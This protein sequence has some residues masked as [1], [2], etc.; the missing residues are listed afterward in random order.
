MPDLFR[1]AR[2]DVGAF[3]E[4]VGHPLAAFQLR[5]LADEAAQTRRAGAHAA[6]TQGDT[7]S[8]RL[9]LRAVGCPA[10]QT[11]PTRDARG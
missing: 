4:M 3:A 11:W 10:G 8:S 9:G 6:F 1:R 5:A 7:A 2:D